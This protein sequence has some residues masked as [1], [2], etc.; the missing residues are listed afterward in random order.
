MPIP[1]AI[2]SPSRHNDNSSSG[3]SA[4]TACGVRLCSQAFGCQAVASLC[5]P[6]AATGAKAYNSPS[7][8]LSLCSPATLI[9]VIKAFAWNGRPVCQTKV[10]GTL[11]RAV[12]PRRLTR[13]TT[14]GHTVLARSLHY[15]IAKEPPA[16][17]A[18]AAQ[19]SP[20]SIKHLSMNKV[21][22]Q[23]SNNGQNLG[24]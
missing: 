13:A 11:R 14:V 20:T 16:A 3:L 9:S 23:N 4:K 24:R 17:C 19:A 6:F 22:G 10:V 8:E 7:G 12:A 2:W 5:E 1:T 18:F 15:Q 21:S